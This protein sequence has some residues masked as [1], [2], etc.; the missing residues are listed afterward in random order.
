VIAGIFFP[1]EPGFLKTSPT[2]S[3]CRLLVNNDVGGVIELS[4]EDVTPCPMASEMASIV[5][6]DV[7]EADRI[8]LKPSGGMEA[9]FA[10]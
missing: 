2:L 10:I 6:I 8:V 9:F 3:T 1:D 5:D 4:T 7:F